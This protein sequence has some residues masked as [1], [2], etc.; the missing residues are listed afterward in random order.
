MKKREFIKAATLAGTGLVLGAVSGQ[1]FKSEKKNK[2]KK[3]I[4]INGSPDENGNTAYALSVIEEI[5]RNENVNFEII[6]IGKSDIRGCIACSKC[7]IEKT[8][9]VHTTDDEKKW[10]E[11]MKNADAI[12]LASPTYFGGIAGTMKSFLDKAFFSSSKNFRNKIGAAVVTTRRTGASMT[13][14][15]LNQ[16]FTISEM[17]VASSTYWNNIRGL[18]VDDLKNDSEGIRTLQNLAKNIIELI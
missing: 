10:I 15:G 9:C 8:V 17:P 4:A 3:V 11:L 6:H 13:F 14:E 12:I 18:T 1:L 2:N 5:F 7:H 16:Y